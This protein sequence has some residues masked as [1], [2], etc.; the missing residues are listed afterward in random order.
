MSKITDAN[1]I[2]ELSSKKFE[3]NLVDGMFAVVA[4]KR[5]IE[6]YM[7]HHNDEENPVW[8]IEECDIEDLEVFNSTHLF[9]DFRA[10]ATLLRDHWFTDAQSAHSW[11]C[12][13]IMKGQLE[14]I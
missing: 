4:Q 7:T 13:Y 14:Q 9:D 3:G 12:E 10:N 1:R 8:L 2:A 5:L 11:F 6:L